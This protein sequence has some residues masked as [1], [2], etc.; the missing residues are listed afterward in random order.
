MPY[1][2]TTPRTF[3][4]EK[5]TSVSITRLR[6]VEYSVQIEP[7]IASS[8]IAALQSGT[9][10]YADETSIRYTFNSDSTTRILTSNPAGANRVSAALEK[11][12]F[13]ELARLGVIPTGTT[14]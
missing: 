6:I 2:L 8:A 10:P 5:P 9:G 4:V 1:V 12:I 3:Q 7:V 14:I 11:G 13:D